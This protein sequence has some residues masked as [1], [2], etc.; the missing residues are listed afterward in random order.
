MNLSIKTKI[1]LIS[2][3]SLF[4]AI[5]ASSLVTGYIFNK[6]Y[7][8][9]RRSEAF[10]VGSILVSQLDRLLKLQIPVNQILGFEEQCQELINENK[11][12][13]YVMVIEP[14]GEIL[15]HNQPEN[16]GEKISDPGILA[17]LSQPDKTWRISEDSSQ[18]Y[19]DLF[20]P[21]RDAENNPIATVRIGFPVTHV[22]D[23]TNWLLYITGL[24]SL[25]FLL[26]GLVIIV[27]GINTWV[28]KP[29]A[30]LLEVIERIR[31]K[32][33]ILNMPV[34][35]NA[36][37]EITKLATS[38]NKM[39]ARLEEDLA[40]RRKIEQQLKTAKEQAE[41]ANAAKSEFLANVSH[42]LRTPMHHI[43]NYSKFGV[44][45]VESVP[46]V[47]LKHYFSQIRK[48]GERLMFLLNDLLDLSK[49]ESGKTDFHME[50]GDLLEILDDVLAELA[51]S[52]LNR[53]IQVIKPTPDFSTIVV[54]DKLRIGQVLNNL[55][56]NAIKFS[57]QQT[58]VTISLA[59]SQIAIDEKVVPALQCSVLD[60]GFGI[61]KDELT[62]IFEK[63]TQSSRTKTGAGGTGLGLAICTEIINAH[64]GSIWAENH[65]RGG[66]VF[67]FKIPIKQEQ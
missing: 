29:L 39:A 53:Q 65:A 27:F 61:P 19:Y 64:R 49:L 52:L 4:T 35:K 8:E 1:L 60:Q 17:I 38:F 31:I 32:G 18:K 23:K 37:D 47:K 50:K 11:F 22:T 30:A 48:T 55:L 5:A 13:S 21:L 16:H 51:I 6:E 62:T 7:A 2:S 9:A 14:S 63:F 3:I 36:R 59:Q 42:E 40:L 58:T 10:V 28:N 33:T 43:M 56:S 57:P 66:A 24:V 54:C 45:K 34:K 26:F 46:L 44:D 15:F 20:I 67:T 12:L 25:G 41:T